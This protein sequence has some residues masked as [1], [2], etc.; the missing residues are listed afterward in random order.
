MNKSLM[1][2]LSGAALVALMAL[3]GAGA[4]SAEQTG[5]TTV[6]VPPGG[7]ACVA[8][9]Q[10]AGYRVRADGSAPNAVGSTTQFSM[11]ESYDGVNF[12]AIA[13]QTLNGNYYGGELMSN[14]YPQYFPSYWKFCVRN[15]GT[16]TNVKATLT[17]KTDNNAF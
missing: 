15:L 16:T 12:Q 14:L 2:S 4:A 6:T 13:S 11:S 5:P 3:G 10:R 8:T 17:L 1:K 7:R 9:L